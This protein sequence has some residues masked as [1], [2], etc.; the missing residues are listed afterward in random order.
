M[1]LIIV[2]SA[3]TNMLQVV[4]FTYVTFDVVNEMRMLSVKL[5]VDIH[6]NVESASH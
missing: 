6:V 5:D 4:M 3:I 1:Y 2:F